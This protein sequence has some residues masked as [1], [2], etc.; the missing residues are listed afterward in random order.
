MPHPT[1]KVKDS[2]L[3]FSDRHAPLF[4][5]LF[6]AASELAL[7]EVLYRASAVL[8]KYKLNHFVL[9]MGTAFFVD[10]E[11]EVHSDNYMDTSEELD[12]LVEFIDE[13]DSTFKFTGEGIKLYSNGKIEELP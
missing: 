9:A 12:N 4:S 1:S 5:A 10:D 6:N 13:W 8:E 3:S 2:K 7:E 11:G